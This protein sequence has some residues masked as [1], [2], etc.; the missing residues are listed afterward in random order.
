MKGIF[1]S[2]ILWE[3]KIC[4]NDDFVNL[5]RDRM[6]EGK[7]YKLPD[8]KDIQQINDVCTKCRFPLL[9]DEKECPICKYKNLQMEINKGR[10]GFVYQ[11]SC[12]ICG[13]TLYS[14]KQFD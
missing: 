2:C 13:R 11:Y 10:F 4:I 6:K 12:D 7:Q 1:E 9:I 5:H 3:K 14:H 8:K